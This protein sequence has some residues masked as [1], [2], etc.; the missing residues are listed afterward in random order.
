MNRVQAGS[1]FS[2]AESP[3]PRTRAVIIFAALFII[4]VIFKLNTLTAPFHWDAMR[5]VI[6]SAEAIQGDWTQIPKTASAGHPPLYYIL[7]VLAWDVFG[8]T[9]LVSHLFDIWLGAIGLTSLLFLGRRLYGWGVAVSATLL[10]LFNQIFFAQVGIVHLEV[11]VMSAEILAVFCYLREKKGLYLVSTMAMLLIK[12]TAAVVLVSI[13]IFDFFRSLARRKRIGAALGRVGFLALPVAPFAI[14]YALHREV[15]GWIANVGGILDPSHFFR[16]FANNFGR[17]LIY[18]TS[19]ETVN[20]AYPLLFL[21]AAAGFVVLFKKK[22]LGAE[23]LFLLIILVHAAFFAVIRDKPMPRYFLAIIPFYA[24]LGARGAVLLSERLPRRN[25]W[26]GLFLLITIGLSVGNYT[27][28]RNTD[29]WRLESNMEYLDMVR[30]H[31]DVGRFLEENYPDYGFVTSFPLRVALANPWYGYVKKSL[32]I[33]DFAGF[34]AQER[35]LVVW[36]AQ[37]NFEDIRKFIKANGDG[38]RLLKQFSHRGKSVRI[39]EK[40]SPSP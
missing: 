12:E 2:R 26:L 39:Y 25:L 27:G 21:A 19:I 5:Y 18:D 3:S 9:R 33:I 35:V 20:R 34:Q 36:S 28:R 4:L 24:L 23:P 29:G 6:P 37:S 16:T 38:I 10:L 13:L 40:R 8:K 15:T 17:H 32:R 7:L 30:L 11:A 31:Q 14:W 22:K 1:V